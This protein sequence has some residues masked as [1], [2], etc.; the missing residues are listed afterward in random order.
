MPKT[1]RDLLKTIAAG[2]GGDFGEQICIAF[3]KQS[4]FNDFIDRPMSDEEFAS[5]FEKITRDLPNVAGTLNS[6]SWQ[7]RGSWGQAN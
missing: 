3:A 2:I 1:K 5:Q 4:S 7:K 6:V